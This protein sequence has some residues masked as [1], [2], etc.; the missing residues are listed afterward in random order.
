VPGGPDALYMNRAILGKVLSSF[1]RL[2]IATTPVGEKQTPSY[3]GIPML[4]IGKKAD[5]T[6]IIPQTETQ[7]SSNVASSIYAV[8]FS[9]SE[10][11]AGTAGLYS[12]TENEPPF[13]VRDLGEIDAK[14]V[15]RTRIEGFLGLAV[16]GKGAARLT[17][18]LNS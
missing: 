4:D 6:E 9:E 15:F 1:R 5:G 7:G 11:E 13:D 16:F 10:Q 18:V 14:P 17:G 3:Q 2:N 12:G 8:R